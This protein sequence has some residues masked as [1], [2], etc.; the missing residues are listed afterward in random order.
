MF[1]VIALVLRRALRDGLSQ[2]AVGPI[3]V[4]PPRWAFI[5]RG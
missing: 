3:C 4:V 5:P 2:Q 1:L